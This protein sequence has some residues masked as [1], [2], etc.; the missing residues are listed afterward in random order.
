[1]EELTVSS[2][3]AFDVVSAAQRFICET[4][5]SNLSEAPAAARR[6]CHG[7]SEPPHPAARVLLRS[8]LIDISS[9][10]GHARHRAVRSRCL[11]P[12]CVP[13]TL[14]DQGLCWSRAWQDQ[15][16]RE[17]EIF[18]AWID[19]F[20][21]EMARTHAEDLALRVAAIIIAN[22]AKPLRVGD[23]AIAVGAHEASVRRAF[24]REFHMSLRE[25]ILQIR[26]ERAECL[27]RETPESKVEP[28]AL[29]VGWRSRKDL[30]RAV[31]KVRGC[32]PGAL[33]RAPD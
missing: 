26:V 20:C 14:A 10:W 2:D 12:L 27:L 17:P 32:T 21:A 16:P 28:V 31:K 7:F 5:D 11:T 4:S 19:A 24:R 13:A 25:Y 8:L 30:Y 1:M 22:L 15:E 23:I 9:R 33:R 18:I 6:F 29:E 3:W